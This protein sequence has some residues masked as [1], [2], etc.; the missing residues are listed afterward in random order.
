M[1]AVQREGE[2]QDG[3][4]AGQAQFAGDHR[5][6]PSG[7]DEVVDEQDGASPSLATAR[8]AGPWARTRRTERGPAGRCCSAGTGGLAGR[9]RS[10]GPSQASRPTAA[11][12]EPSEV[13]SAGRMLDGTA[14][15]AAGRC[16]QRHVR[17]TSTT[18]ANTSSGTVRYRRGPATAG[19]VPARRRAPPEPSR[20]RSRNR[21]PQPMSLRRP[22]TRPRS[23]CSAAAI[24]PDSGTP[25]DARPVGH[26]RRGS[27]SAPGLARSSRPA[28]SA[29]GLTSSGQGG[30]YRCHNVRTLSPARRRAGGAGTPSGS[31]RRRYSRASPAARRRAPPRPARTGPRRRSTAGRSLTQPPCTRRTAASTSRTLSIISS[32][33]RDRST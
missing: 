14:T 33:D 32:R 19:S 15:T 31:R 30:P 4:R 26:I 2:G 7:V 17:S 23:A 27:M 20:N 22:S 9:T 24:R 11:I 16:S 21:G 28:A 18:A 3:R 10:T 29:P 8:T 12:R 25:T 1:S 13:T 6:S 5:C